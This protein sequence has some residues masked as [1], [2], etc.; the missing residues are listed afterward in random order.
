MQPSYLQY[1]LNKAYRN[2]I[3]ASGTLEL[4]ARCNLSCKMCYIHKAEN[5]GAALAKELPPLFGWI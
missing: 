1:V 4:T 2:K 3:A 5:D